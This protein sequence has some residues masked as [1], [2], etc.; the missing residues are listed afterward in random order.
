MDLSRRALL[1]WGGGAAVLAAGGTYELIQHGVLPGKYRLARISGACGDDPGVPAVATGPVLSERF[2]SRYRHTVVEMI[3]MRPPSAPGPL[4][5]A[6]V[7]H[8]A[9]S[10]AAGAVSLGYPAYLAAAVRAGARPFA[11]VAVDGGSLF[12]HR[13]SSG[14]DPQR[15][16]LAEV[17]PRLAGRGYHTGTFGLAGWSMGGYG[18]LLLAARLGTGVAA[19]AVSSPA[20]F[21]SYP[22][23]I[24]A[25]PGS[26]DNAADFAA[27]DVRSS[28]DLAALRRLPVRI[29]CG[30]DDPFAPRD[31]ALRTD[32]G[33]PAGAISAGCHDQA[34]WRRTLPAQLGFVAAHLG[35]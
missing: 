30:A 34:F 15:M 20:I 35:G 21:G 19:V 17:L 32:L 8:G 1:A 14:D 18:A 33:G 3:T 5:V 10:S 13:R 31:T 26:F 16:L 24:A 29:D 9:G 28:A 22:D 7:L 27:N 12:W 2:Y 25:N 6:L 11:A 4:P 23:A